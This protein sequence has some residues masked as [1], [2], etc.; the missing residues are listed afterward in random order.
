M[1]NKKDQGRPPTLFELVGTNVM[2]MAVAAVCVRAVIWREPK[3]VTVVLWAAVAFSLAI[4]F[5]LTSKIR[6]RGK[7]GNKRGS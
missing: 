7:G 6:R 5:L 1:Q 3:L 2:A 4:T